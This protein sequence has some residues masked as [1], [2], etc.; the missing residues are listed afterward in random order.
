MNRI[1]IALITNFFPNSEQPYRGMSTYRL[2]QSLSA[3]ADVDVV[4]PL[5]HYPKW[6]TPK[7]FDHRQ[8]DLEHRLPEVNVK[9][10]EF[11]AIPVVTRALNGKIC[12]ARLL[13]H[14]RSLDP[15]LIL[16]YW[17]YPQGYA[18][19]AIGETLGIPSIVGS[20][21][22]DL[23]G[24]SDCVTRFYT[25]LTLRRATLVVTKSRSLCREAI[26]LGAKPSKTHAVL[27][28]C[29]TGV[30][31]ISDREQA[32]KEL[33]ISAPDQLIL[34]VGR[35]SLTK[36]LLELVESLAILRERHRAV[37]LVLVGEGPNQ[38]IIVERALKL[39]VAEHVLFVP[40]QSPQCVSRWLAAATLLTLPSYSEGFPN[41]VLEAVSC[42]RPVVATRV[43]GIPEIVDD[44]CGIL[45]P[46]RDVT[47]LS[48]ALEVAL[49]RDWNEQMIAN[50]FKRSWDDMARELYGVCLSAL[51]PTA[52]AV[53]AKAKVAQTV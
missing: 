33:G 41:V 35:L 44:R 40:P 43:G 27:N 36:G 16:N 10:V 26:R 52:F 4:C 22:T 46:P 51:S 32:R 31:H 50:C 15:D 30:F 18:A 2:V 53:E 19:V 6:L 21:G 45:V 7:S 28:G 20:I 24:L 48:Q 25:R 12:A 14:I 8:I 13:N 42:G 39:G 34:F 49:N 47:G 9:Y 5:P 37:Q 1:H 17:L 29:D 11:P 23:N 38:D 3:F